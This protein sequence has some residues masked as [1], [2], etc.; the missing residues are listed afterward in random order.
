VL[1]NVEAALST[2]AAEISSTLASVAAGI[3]K[4]NPSHQLCV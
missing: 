2:A 1:R 3:I 4:L